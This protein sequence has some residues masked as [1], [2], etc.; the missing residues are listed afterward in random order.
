MSLNDDVLFLKFLLLNLSRPFF[1]SRYAVLFY[2]STEA[3]SY[4]ELMLLNKMLGI[5]P[6]RSGGGRGEGVKE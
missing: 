3:G 6:V 1:N 5:S 2:N 4:E